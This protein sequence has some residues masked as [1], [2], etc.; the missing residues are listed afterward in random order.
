MIRSP[1]EHLRPRLSLGFQACH[2]W[3]LVLFKMLRDGVQHNCQFSF[4]FSNLKHWRGRTKSNLVTSSWTFCIH[5]KTFHPLPTKI[6]N[7]E[8]TLQALLDSVVPSYKSDPKQD[9][10]RERTHHT[11]M[12]QDRNLAKEWHIWAKI[13]VLRK[14]TQ[15]FTIRR[16]KFHRFLVSIVKYMLIIVGRIGPDELVQPSYIL[17]T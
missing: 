9:F 15:I 16:V 17:K 14:L 3:F 12:G 1:L 4:V 6:S 13:P 5:A 11:H 2:W 10:L 7:D 8:V